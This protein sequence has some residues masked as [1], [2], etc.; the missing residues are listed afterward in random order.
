MLTKTEQQLLMYPANSTLRA[1]EL[2]CV[3]GE[4]C[5]FEKLT[6]EVRSGNCLHILGANGSGKSSLLKILCGLTQA[7]SGL[8]FWQGNPINK[9][10][11]FENIAYIGHRDGLKNE[12]TAVENLR[13][14]QHLE[15]SANSEDEI[16][17][18]L[19]LM[20]IIDCADLTTDKLSFGQRRRLAFA[21][22]LQAN[23]AL[24]ILDE[25]FTGV[26]RTGRQLIENLCL[27]HLERQGMIILTNHQNLVNS[28]MAHYLSELIL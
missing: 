19:A 24:W 20:G 14:Y 3:R 26:D 22:L 9:T 17:Q 28:A 21:R 5:L 27:T 1:E 13:F 4:R 23:F 10:A 18:Q 8:V 16:D 2:R 7:E 25:P 6:F 11:F 15:R 12:L